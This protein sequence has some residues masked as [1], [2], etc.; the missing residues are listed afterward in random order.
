VAL[1]KCRRDH[2]AIQKERFFRSISLLKKSVKI[3]HRVYIFDNLERELKLIVSFSNG[4]VDKIFEPKMPE[5]LNVLAI[6][7]NDE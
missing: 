2:R 6:N 5:W 3:F 4:T 1:V 7:K